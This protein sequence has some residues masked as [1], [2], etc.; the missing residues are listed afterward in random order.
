MMEKL[1]GLNIVDDYNMNNRENIEN[2]KVVGE[3]SREVYNNLCVEKHMLL[4]QSLL[5]VF[6]KCK[7]LVHRHQLELS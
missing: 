6:T 2:I 5:K 3:I 7:E 4:R 1:T